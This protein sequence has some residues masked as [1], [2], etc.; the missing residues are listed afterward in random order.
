M[1]IRS[2]RRAAFSLTEALIAIFCV[3]IGLMG[4][5]VLFPIGALQMAQSIKDDRSAQANHHATTRMRQSWRDEVLKQPVPRYSP[6]FNIATGAYQGYRDPFVDA[7]LDVN[8][9]YTKPPYAPPYVPGGNANGSVV[10]INYQSNIAVQG[11]GPTAPL[12]FYRNGPSYP[13]FLDP[14]GWQNATNVAAGAQRYW[15]GGFPGSIPRRTL[16]GLDPTAAFPVGAPQYSLVGWCIQTDD[17]A[18][19][20]DGSPDTI[21]KQRDTSYSVGGFVPFTTNGFNVQYDGRYNW[22]YLLRRPKCINWDQA[23]LSVVVYSGRSLDGPNREIPYASSRFTQGSTEVIMPYAGSRPNVRKGTWILDAT[24]FNYVTMQPDPHG[25]FYR[26][27]NVNDDN[28]GVLILEIQNPAKQSSVDVNTNT[29]Y[30]ITIMMEHVVE[31]FDR[32]TLTK[33]IVPVP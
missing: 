32:S 1:L 16:L 31:V 6:F 28:P 7:M 14:I 25:F 33:V 11:L 29:P 13:V 5:L 15:V 4:I 22:A 21:N 10:P 30:G 24:M 18:W 19:G 27:V 3:A 8:G 20:R 26:V 12:P 17:Q 23:D 2:S 9:P